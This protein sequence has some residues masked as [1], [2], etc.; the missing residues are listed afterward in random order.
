MFKKYE[1]HKSTIFDLDANY[2]V[3]ILWIVTIL[4][5]NDSFGGTVVS[6]ALPFIVLFLE[7]KSQLVRVH[8]GQIAVLILSVTMIKMLLN[9][10]SGVLYALSSFLG[11]WMLPVT[12]IGILFSVISWIIVSILVVCAVFGCTQGY[13][14]KEWK[15]PIL[16][17]FGEILTRKV[18]LK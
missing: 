16:E 9:L 15:V 3:I 18:K 6:L 10:I 8:A 13:H 4:C 14:W 12:T 7:K 17:E 2:V 1:P 11:F 5:H